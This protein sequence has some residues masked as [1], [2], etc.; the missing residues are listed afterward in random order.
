M[1]PE[2]LN[3]SQ[4]I[5]AFTDTSKLL[6]ENWLKWSVNNPHSVGLRTSGNEQIGPLYIPYIDLPMC[7]AVQ[8]VFSARN[9]RPSDEIPFLFFFPPGLSSWNQ[10]ECGVDLGQELQAL[11]DASPDGEQF[12]FGECDVMSSS[13]NSMKL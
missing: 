2:S 10:Q 13:S 12:K 5:T 8:E 9:F 6:K 1:V 11:I 3:M 4:L 7:S